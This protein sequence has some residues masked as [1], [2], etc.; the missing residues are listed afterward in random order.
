MEGSL[1]N[2]KFDRTIKTYLFQQ[3]INSKLMKLIDEVSDSRAEPKDIVTI[4][5]LQIYIKAL[6][7]IKG[8]EKREVKIVWLDKTSIANYNDTQTKYLV[9]LLPP[10]IELIEQVAAFIKNLKDKGIQKTYH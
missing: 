3:Y 5:D 10:R 7:D 9:F 2:K 4:P 8:L 1:F 6:W